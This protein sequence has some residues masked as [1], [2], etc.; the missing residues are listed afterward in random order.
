MTSGTRLKAFM[1][2][3]SAASPPASGCR[4]GSQRFTGARLLRSPGSGFWARLRFCG[5]KS[6]QGALGGG[7]DGARVQ[8]GWG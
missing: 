2:S 5:K 6:H 3:D 4:S 7:R 8:W 1:D